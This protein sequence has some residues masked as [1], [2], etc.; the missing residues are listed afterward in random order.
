MAIKDKT[1]D[2]FAAKLEPIHSKYKLLN[3][4]FK[5]LRYLHYVCSTIS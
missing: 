5:L 4:E 3:Y 1:E 2:T